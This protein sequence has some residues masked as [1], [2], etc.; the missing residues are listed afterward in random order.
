MLLYRVFPWD[1]QSTGRGPGGP[2][3]V[4]RERQGSGRHDSPE[5]YGA[6]YCSL[7]AVSAIAEAIQFLR[8]HTLTP[9]DLRRFGGLVTSLATIRLGDDLKL[10][11]LDDPV[12]LL[13]WKLRPSE[14]A[15]GTRAIS[16]RIAQRIHS[17]GEAG[18]LW[19]STLEA[20]WM[21][22]TLFDERVRASLKLESP[23][24]ALTTRHP[25][26]LAAVD[27]LGIDLEPRS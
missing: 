18:L 19:W 4:P 3:H 16:Q 2:L 27:R 12:T 24:V 5:L 11:D 13:E 14:V 20:A 9:T 21:N 25:E 8:G 22:A 23:P 17:T 15:T 1:R 7:H 10:V 6:L 26:L